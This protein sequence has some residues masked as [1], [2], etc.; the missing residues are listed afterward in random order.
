MVA[1]GLKKSPAQT[2][3]EYE[4][5]VG[6]AFIPVTFCP[7]QM[8]SGKN[9]G[10]GEQFWAYKLTTVNRV[11]IPENRIFRINRG[12]LNQRNKVKLISPEYE[13]PKLS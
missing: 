6:P 8:V 1:P 9:T 4:F 10:K 5:S 11:N 7:R 3:Q 13:T 2:S 12:I